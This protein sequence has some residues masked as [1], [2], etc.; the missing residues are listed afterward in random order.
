MKKS[1]RQ[2][3]SAVAL[4]AIT[5]CTT[6]PYLKPDAPSCVYSTVNPS[7]PGAQE[8]VAFTPKNQPW[9]FLRVYAT[10]P[11]R[12]N[13]K[14]TELRVHV[15][16]QFFVGVDSFFPTDEQRKT[17]KERSDR[18]YRVTTSK[19]AVTVV[20]PDGTNKEVFIPIFEKPY[21]PKTDKTSRWD[22]GVQLS[23]G[24]L[25][26]FTVI[27]PEVFVNGEK[28]EVPPIHFKKQE[29]RYAPVLNC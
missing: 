21:N 8:V 9:V 11:T 17:V 4:A 18:H 6:G 28:I 13:S 27:F 10:P 5:G 20:L 25:D 22:N 23:P 7:C 12:W 15:E 2:I 19:A 1:L 24:N 29:D 26:R 16:L 3:Y 14:G